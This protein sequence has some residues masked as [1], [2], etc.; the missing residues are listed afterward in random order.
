MAAPTSKKSLKIAVSNFGPIIEANIDL[1]PLTVFVGPSNTGKSY[2]AILIYALQRFFSIPARLDIPKKARRDMAVWLERAA[3]GAAPKPLPKSVESLALQF[4]NISGSRGG[5][6]A[7]EM[8]RCF[9]IDNL[10]RLTRYGSGAKAK[11]AI[12]ISVGEAAAASLRVC[13]I[14]RFTPPAA[15]A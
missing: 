3:G 13:L 4:L 12:K 2:M 8:R 10:G 1:R 11:V 6:L 14:I 9:G 5:A 15:S 7:E